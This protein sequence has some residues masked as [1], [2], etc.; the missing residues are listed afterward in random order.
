MMKSSSFKSA[1]ILFGL[2]LFTVNSS[3]HA[4]D[5]SVICSNNMRDLLLDVRS[6]YERTTGH[7]IKVSYASG[8]GVAARIQSGQ[9]AD[10]VLV[11]RD[12]IERLSKE[13]RVVPS[14]IKDVA[15]SVMGVFGR[16]GREA[17]SLRTPDETRKF[18]LGVSSLVYPNP[19]KGISGSVVEAMLIR[20]NIGDELKS[21]IRLTDDT[22]DM[23][24]IVA[25]G[26]AEFG[27]SQVTRATGD[28]VTLVAILPASAGGQTVLSAAVVDGTR[29][30]AASHSLV[31][32]L[33]SSETT[34]AVKANGLQR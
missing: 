28:D 16:K 25:A 24:R 14:T 5:L 21:R 26:E 17:V 29:K 12:I 6:E 22:R 30:P 15:I 9:S 20:L 13:S 33:A 4:E 7:N 1:M 27:I 11:Q 31:D 19:S 8:V 34:A 32:F 18:L 23:V 3:A 2:T 10:V